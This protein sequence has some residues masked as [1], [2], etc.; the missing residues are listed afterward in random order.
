[1]KFET[2]K[3]FKTISGKGNVELV[4]IQSI[5]SWQAFQKMTIQKRIPVIPTNKDDRSLTSP[6]WCLMV[7]C[8]FIHGSDYQWIP[9]T[10]S[11]CCK[12]YNYLEPKDVMLT[13]RSTVASLL[14]SI[15]WTSLVWFQTRVWLRLIVCPNK[16]SMNL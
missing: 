13:P 10:A 11:I 9:F 14:S 4:F 1:M 5:M 15:F 7:R 16:L 2:A 3:L 12:I 6:V 8:G